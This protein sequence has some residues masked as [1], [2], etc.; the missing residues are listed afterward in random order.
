MKIMQCLSRIFAVCLQT[1]ILKVGEIEKINS[2]KT[3]T[4][5]WLFAHIIGNS[6]VL[7]VHSA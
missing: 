1:I 4:K 7:Q 3:H 2:Q 6:K 5:V